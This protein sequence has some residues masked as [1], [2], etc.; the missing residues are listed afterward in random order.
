MDSC[1]YVHYEVD[2]PDVQNKPEYLEKGIMKSSAA[3]GDAITLTPPQVSFFA[4]SGP[5]T[6]HT[7]SFTHNYVFEA[8]Q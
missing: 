3:D 4:L 1:K 8:C 7:R 6:L 5:T 2:Y